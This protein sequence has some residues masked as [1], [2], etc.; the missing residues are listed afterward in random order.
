MREMKDIYDIKNRK[1]YRVKRN[2]RNRLTLEE[3]IYENIIR[4]PTSG[5]IIY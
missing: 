2:W 4:F 3:I 5:D 1:W